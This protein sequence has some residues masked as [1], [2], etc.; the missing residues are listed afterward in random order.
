MSILFKEMLTLY[1]KTFIWSNT[2]KIPIK[3]F[4]DLNM[5]Q[6]YPVFVLAHK[7]TE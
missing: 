7:I 3:V 5:V 1:F 2:H 6:R 4:A